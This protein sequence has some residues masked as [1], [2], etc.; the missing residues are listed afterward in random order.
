MEKIGKA[1]NVGS[2]DVHEEE[3]SRIVANCSALTKW[4]N[5]KEGIRTNLNAITS[6]G[7][8]CYNFYISHR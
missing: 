2:K 7:V 5:F 3:K 1:R 4:L 6:L 8:R